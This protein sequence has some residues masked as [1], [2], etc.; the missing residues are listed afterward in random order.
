MREGL[1][2]QRERDRNKWCYVTMRNRSAEWVVHWVS[3][4]VG[5]SWRS[6]WLKGGSFTGSVTMKNGSTEWDGSSFIEVGWIEHSSSHGGD[7][8][9][10]L[11]YICY[12]WTFI[13][14][15]KTKGQYYTHLDCK[16]GEMWNWG[17][18]RFKIN[19]SPM[20][21]EKNNTGLSCDEERKKERRKGWESPKD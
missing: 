7:E 8:D 15:T 12:G 18:L 2:W 17:L 20:P 11:T 4:G 19:R 9:D 14:K 5:C 10:N 13:L 16:L 6:D 3:S 1:K 21:K